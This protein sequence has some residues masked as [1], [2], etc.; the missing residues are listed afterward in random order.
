VNVLSVVLATAAFVVALV[1]LYLS[2]VRRADIE[3]IQL[4][5]RISVPQQKRRDEGPAEWAELRI[6]VAA[7]NSGAR[8]GVITDLT[9]QLSSGRLF[10][11]DSGNPNPNFRDDLLGALPVLS[12]ETTVFNI[13]VATTF[14]NE[15]VAEWRNGSFSS[16]DVRVSYTFL[17]GTRIR[18]YATRELVL[19]VPVETVVYV[20]QP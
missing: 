4:P 12:G 14:S 20:A 16:F 7:I 18:R 13:E 9:V 19:R 11:I 6:S 5:R 15:A 17:R 1:T 3:L 2:N 10:T 8:P